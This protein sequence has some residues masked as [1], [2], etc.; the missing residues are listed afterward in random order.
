MSF[1]GFAFSPDCG[2]CFAPLKNDFPGPFLVSPIR[3]KISKRQKNSSKVHWNRVNESLRTP[4]T[5]NGHD[6]FHVHESGGNHM[7]H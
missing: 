6:R 3:R 5:K 7:F 1:G 4:I 2:E